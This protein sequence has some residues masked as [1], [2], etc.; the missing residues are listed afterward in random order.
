MNKNKIIGHLSAFLGCV[1]L[2]G[3]ISGI[4]GKV[5]GFNTLAAFLY[6]AFGQVRV[7]SLVEKKLEK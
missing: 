5:F 3:I 7:A 1:I 2:A 6:G 4:E